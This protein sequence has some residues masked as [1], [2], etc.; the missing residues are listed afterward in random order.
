[1]STQ[2]AVRVVEANVDTQTDTLATLRMYMYH[3]VATTSTLETFPAHP[4]P[5]FPE[6]PVGSSVTKVPPTITLTIMG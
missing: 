2:N 3:Q 1:M 6:E 4:L 5:N